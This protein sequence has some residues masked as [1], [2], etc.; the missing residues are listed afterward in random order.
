[1]GT[2]KVLQVIE[3]PQVFDGLVLVWMLGIV[4]YKVMYGVTGIT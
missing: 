2:L 4:R 3:N 1:M